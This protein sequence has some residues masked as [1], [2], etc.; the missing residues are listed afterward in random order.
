[1]QR[2]QQRINKPG[3]AASKTIDKPGAAPGAANKTI[4][5]QQRQGMGGAI[6]NS[7]HPNAPS[8]FIYILTDL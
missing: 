4:I 6:W 5:E 3:A 7:T 8:H 2:E 1:M